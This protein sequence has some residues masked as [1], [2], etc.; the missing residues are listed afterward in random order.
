MKSVKKELI[1]ISVLLFAFVAVGFASLIK[2]HTREPEIEYRDRI[3][4]VEKPIEVIR[5][6]EVI[7]E[8]KVPVEVEKIVEKEVIVERSEVDLNGLDVV[9]VHN[10]LYEFEFTAYQF[11][12]NSSPIEQVFELH[13]LDTTMDYSGSYIFKSGELIS[14]PGY[15]IRD[16]VLT[17]PRQMATPYVLDSGGNNISPSNIIDSSNVVG[18]VFKYENLSREQIHISFGYARM[19]RELYGAE[20]VRVTF[21]IRY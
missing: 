8:V 18:S 2:G 4:E 5:E 12:K 9:R 15:I 1:L 7:K 17:N 11:Y 19:G 13:G 10:N 20:S 16:I 3:V 14:K 6:V 21:S